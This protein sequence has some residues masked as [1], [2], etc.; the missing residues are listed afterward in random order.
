MKRLK[1][2]LLA[3]LLGGSVTVPNHAIDPVFTAAAP[4]LVIAQVREFGPDARVRVANVGSANSGPCALRVWHFNGAFWAVTATVGVPPV[5]KG[6]SVW[7]PIHAG[8]IAAALNVYRVDVFNVV[9]EL[10][11]GNNGFQTP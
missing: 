5:A 2:S 10:L 6:T 11:E 8:G 4:D 3:L 1:I 9:P 7:I